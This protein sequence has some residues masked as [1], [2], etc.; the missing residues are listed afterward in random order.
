MNKKYINY[1]YVLSFVLVILSIM[2]CGNETKISKEDM[3]FDTV[4]YLQKSPRV[5][6][7]KSTSSKYINLGSVPIKNFIIVDTIMFVDTGRDKGI[8]EIFSMKGYSSKGRLINKGRASGEFIQGINLGLY[9]TFMKK[10]Q[11]L[12][13]TIYDMVTG[14]LYSLNVSDFLSEGKYKLVEIYRNTEMPQ[15]AFWVKQLSDSILFTKVLTD[16]ET[17]QKRYLIKNGKIG[18]TPNLDFADNFVVPKNEDFNLLS[19]LIGVSPDGNKCVEAMLGMNYINVY[20]PINGRGYTICCGDKIDKLSEALSLPKAKRKY[21]FA[22]IRTYDF[23]FAILKYDITEKEFQSGEDF[24]PSILIF[25]WKGNTLG[26]VKPEVNFNHF[27]I[28]INKELLYILDTNGRIMR[29]DIPIVKL[30]E[31]R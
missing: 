5:L 4:K 8:V 18:K 29:Y 10:G 30:L 2:S 24:I 16:E 11:V 12:Y 14:K 22:D 26:E 13:G 15:P 7:L 28:D 25:D 23:G 31:R 27:D 17:A 21:M 1:I 20:S 6:V 3:A 19:T 9:T